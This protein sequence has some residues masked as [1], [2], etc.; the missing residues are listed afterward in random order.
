MVQGVCKGCH[1]EVTTHA[2]SSPD[3]RVP[4]CVVCN[5]DVSDE[6]GYEARQGYSVEACRG[7]PE[8]VNLRRSIARLR[9]RGGTYRV[10]GYRRMQRLGIGGSGVAWLCERQSDGTRVVLKLMLPDR[11]VDTNARSHFE[12]E[13]AS[14]W[15]LGLG[16]N[17]I[18]QYDRGEADG[19]LWFAMEYCEFGSLEALVERC[20]GRLDVRESVN[21]T[22]QALAGIEAMHSRGFV[23]R[24]F[25]PANVL[26]AKRE[27]RGVVKVANLGLAHCFER[28]GL[29]HDRYRLGVGLGPVHATRTARA[30]PI[31]AA[32]ERRVGCGG[33]AVLFV[34]WPHLPRLHGQPGCTTDGFVRAD[35]S[36]S[37][38]RSEYPP[39]V[40]RGDRPR[41][42]LRREGA[43]ANRSAVWARA[44]GCDGKLRRGVKDVLNL[45]ATQTD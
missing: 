42:A 28:A 18:E 19:V 10:S 8:A 5:E 43:D 24:D 2:L 6:V 26:L 45:A 41:V 17:L 39:T 4:H 37:G 22:L 12:R 32:G 30:I 31:R 21:I 35:R 16:P 23:H 33:N 3:Q 11:A 15:L 38:A 9:A 40:G 1:P 27:G 13:S 14:M 44:A 25:K 34:E 29:R 36:D 7:V 20:G